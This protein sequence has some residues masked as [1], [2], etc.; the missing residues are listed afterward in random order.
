MEHPESLLPVSNTPI[1]ASV[2]DNKGLQRKR[3][4]FETTPPISTYVF[5][6]AL[7]NEYETEQRLV[8]TELVVE[9]L[10]PRGQAILYRWLYDAVV[11]PMRFMGGS[12][13]FRYPL[14]RIAFLMIDPFPYAGVENFGLITLN[15][16]LVKG[17]LPE[18]PGR[19]LVNHEIVHQWFGGVV[20]VTD[21]R[22]ICVQEGLTTFYEWAMSAQTLKA[23]IGTSQNLTVGDRARRAL[24]SFI[25]DYQP[26]LR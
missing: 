10:A 7:L 4:C 1:R 9:I 24:A 14:K 11:E 13:R 3:T 25:D 16:R 12:T 26:F 5:T 8:D 22:E 20:T 19:V 18:V 17:P 6:F 2:G 15:S 23:V 21:W